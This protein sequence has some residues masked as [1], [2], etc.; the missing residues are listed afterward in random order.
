MGRILLFEK[1]I[2]FL[3]CNEVM[4]FGRNMLIWLMGWL[5]V[6]MVL[7]G[8]I[9]MLFSFSGIKIGV[10][11]WFSIVKLLWVIRLLFWF[12]VKD[13]LWVRCLLLGVWIRKN[14]FFL[15]VR[16]NVLLVLDRLFCVK[17]VFCV[18]VV[19]SDSVVLF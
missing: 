18:L 16:L 3:C 19:V 14:L 9:M 12:G 10:L 5:F 8:V 17:I 6:D 7:L 11:F 1:C 15:I 13:L 2:L 4:L